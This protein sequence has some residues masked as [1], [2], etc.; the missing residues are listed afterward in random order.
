MNA[1]Q[2]LADL[3]KGPASGGYLF[4]GPETFVADQLVAAA[5]DAWLDAGTRDF[6]MVRLSGGD[7][8]PQALAGQLSSQ[9][10][11]SPNRIVRVTSME[12]LPAG[13][14]EGVVTAFRQK[15]ADTVLLVEAIQLDRRRKAADWLTKNCVVVEC[16]ALKEPE[17]A[18]WVQAQ[19]EKSGLQF[20][21][22]VPS[23]VVRRAG[24]DLHTLA[25]EVEKLVLY[26]GSEAQR[27]TRRDCEQIIPAH[28]EEQVFGLLDAVGTHNL[29]T[30]VAKLQSLLD[31]GQPETLI[32]FMLAKHF[33]Q[34]Y[35][36]RHLS[37]HGAN[38][39]EIGKALGLRYDFQVRKVLEQS[40]LNSEFRTR[41][42]LRRLRDGDA[43]IKSGSREPRVELEL[44]LLDLCSGPGTLQG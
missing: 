38:P 29:R 25:G 28:P 34:V 2:F 39:A 6:N 14:D 7:L 9:P 16:P 22:G 13:R 32:L 35:L 3:K 42:A 36:A 17:A 5:I 31:S 24:T 37:E 15:A 27:V 33:R 43:A 26:C 21:A 20:E 19:L 41:C 44:V 4:L 8:D 23:E 1:K 11:M 18:A 30:A 10:F 40:R 12:E